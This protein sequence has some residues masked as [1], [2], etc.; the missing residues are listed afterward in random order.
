MLVYRSV[1][2]Y[3]YECITFILLVAAF[4]IITTHCSHHYLFNL[5]GQLKSEA[6]I[7]IF[8]DVAAVV[9]HYWLQRCFPIPSR[10]FQKSFNMIKHLNISSSC[11]YSTGFEFTFQFEHSATSFHLVE[12]LVIFVQ[13]FLQSGYVELPLQQKKFI[14]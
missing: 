12:V 13:T 10:L 1:F 8:F 2:P 6:N 3:V 4:Q 9:K 7:L 5:T 14:V 11:R